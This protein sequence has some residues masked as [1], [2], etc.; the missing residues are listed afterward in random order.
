MLEKYQVRFY[1]TIYVL[2][3]K[4]VIRYKHVRGE[5]MDKA[6]EAL[7]KESAN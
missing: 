4:G 5:K 7:L 6:V 2:D 1:P 3:A